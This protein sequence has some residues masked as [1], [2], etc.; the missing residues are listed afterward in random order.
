ML[1]QEIGHIAAEAL[2]DDNT[3]DN[4]LFTM[5]G[6]LEAG[7]SQPWRRLVSA[8]YLNLDLSVPQF[9]LKAWSILLLVVEYTTLAGRKRFSP[10][11]I[12]SLTANSTV[13]MGRMQTMVA[14]L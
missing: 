8:C 4:K 12:C 1:E 9:S 13:E 3:L 11:Q 5:R 14:E 10:L 7:T 6:I 2:F